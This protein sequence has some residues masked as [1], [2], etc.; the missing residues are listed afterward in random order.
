MYQTDM[1]TYM[2]VYL[3]HEQV[4]DNV[5]GMHMYIYLIQYYVNNDLH[6]RSHHPGCKFVDCSDI[7]E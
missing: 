6:S 1:Y 4:H 5:E 2:Y 7:F 3:L